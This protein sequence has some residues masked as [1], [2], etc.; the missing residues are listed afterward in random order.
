MTESL[1][2]IINVISAPQ[3]TFTALLAVFFF[4]FPPTDRL[5]KI[6]QRLGLS[7]IWTNRGLAVLLGAI[8]VFFL[9]G[10]TDS[11]FRQIVAKPDN[12]PIV[13]LIFLVV[14]FLWF[15]MKQA[16]DNDARIDAGEPPGEALDAREKVLVWPDLVYIELIAMVVTLA[17]LAVW[18]AALPAPLEEPANPTVSPNPSKAPWYFLGLQEMLVYFDPWI[19]GVVFPT[20]ILIGF[21]AIPFIDN[22]PRGSGYYSFKQRKM[23]V[24]IFLFYWIALWIFLILTG[25]FLRGPNWNFFG[26]FEVWDIHK[27]VALNN[28]NISEL[29]YMIWLGRPLPGNILLREAPGLLLVGFYLGVLPLLLART[30]MKKI[31]QSLGPARYSIF[32]IFFLLSISLPVKMY[33]RWA[34][35]IKY[36]VSIPEFFF[37]I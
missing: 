15:A 33:L 32:V 29:V 9:F 24:S 20:V 21:M 23:A 18:S 5:Y 22:N 30:L 11:N 3:I 6:N 26:P 8:L 34:F 2:H 7:K 13:A 36:I 28:I 12:V 16:R 1:K 14:F 10:L 17:V 37:N 25:T 4:V 27:V 19:A 31:C 35:N